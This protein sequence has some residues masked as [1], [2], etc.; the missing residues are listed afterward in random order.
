MRKI[1][2]KEDEKKRERRNQVIIGVALLLLMLTS[3][4]AYSLNNA[5]QTSTNNLI[6]KGLTFI[7]NDNG[8]T[9]KKGSYNFSFIYSPQETQDLNVSLV[10][11]VN[12]SLNLL[13]K[14]YLLLDYYL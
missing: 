6:Y 5:S 11:A 14:Y 2:P 12:S 8:W 7:K 3:A 1:I 4:I 13:N 10:L 9:L